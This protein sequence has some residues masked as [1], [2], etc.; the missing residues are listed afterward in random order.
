MSDD[1]DEFGKPEVPN[2]FGLGFDGFGG[3]GRRRAYFPPLPGDIYLHGENPAKV[4]VPFLLDGDQ[5]LL[6][7]V[8][9]RIYFSSTIKTIPQSSIGELIAAPIDGITRNL[10]GID[11]VN[12]TSSPVICTLYWSSGSPTADEIFGICGGSIAANGLW[13]WRGSLYLDDRGVW[14]QAGTAS[15][16][17]AYFSVAATESTWR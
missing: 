10:I 3:F 4:M 8:A 5:R 11:I 13:S 7:R 16:L 6:L 9:S 12:T 14:G 15:A 17:R 2:E 1:Y